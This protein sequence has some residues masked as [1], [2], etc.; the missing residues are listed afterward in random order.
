M[1]HR[2]LASSFNRWTRETAKLQRDR[3]VVRRALERMRRKSLASAFYEW[4]DLMD[5]R[6][7]FAEKAVTADR[8]VMAMRHRGAFRTK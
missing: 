2:S 5:D 3:V 4:S 1:Q 7:R 8:F 6:R